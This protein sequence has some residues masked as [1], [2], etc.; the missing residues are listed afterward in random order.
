MAKS[1]Q[2]QLLKAGLVNAHKAK[3]IKHE[4]HK[5]TKQ[6][7]PAQNGAAEAKLRAQQAQAEKAERD[8]ENNRQRQLDTERK[9]VAAQ[10][11]QLIEQHRVASGNGD[12]LYQ[13][14]EGGKVKRIYIDET[15]RDQLACG[16]LA[17]VKCEF[18]YEL[19]PAAAAEKIRER[20]AAAVLVLNSKKTQAAENKD[21]PYADYQVPDDLIW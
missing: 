3:Q 8:R 4:K 12:V 9:A 5:Q 17:I 2:E 1:L 20:D 10:I 16:L 19:V 14:V 15:Q 11:K 6:P 18:R 21:D 13:F 7:Q